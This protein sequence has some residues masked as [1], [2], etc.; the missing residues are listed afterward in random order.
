V[1]I[2]IHISYYWKKLIIAGQLKRVNE[3]NMTEKG[4][5]DIEHHVKIIIQKYSCYSE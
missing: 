4:L 1:V 3:G 5:G 2:Q